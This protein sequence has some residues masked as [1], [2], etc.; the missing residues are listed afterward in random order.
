VTEFSGFSGCGDIRHA[1]GVYVLGAVDPAERAVV[2]AHLSTCP[3]CREELAGL[4]GL[5]A[6]L[7]RVPLHDAERL[8]AGDGGP[9]DFEEPPAELLDSLLRRIA[10]R[11]RSRRWR[12]LAAAAAAAV[13]A[14]GAGIGGGTLIAHGPAAS[15]PGAHAVK[16]QEPEVVVGFNPRTHVTAVVSYMQ[17]TRR[18]GGQPRN[19]SQTDMK[20]AVTGIRSGT[21]CQFWVTTFSGHVLLVGGWIVSTDHDS[22]WYG[23]ATSPV[24]AA[25]VRSFAITKDG[26]VLVTI[27]AT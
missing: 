13:I 1:L 10:A 21:F 7:G 5:P 26:K 15:G 8:A 19:R 22:N 2:D 16:Q 17:D 3:E 23:P 11:R 4:A 6:L 20:V 27:P 24:A 14:V 25:S 9:G 18:A 12:G